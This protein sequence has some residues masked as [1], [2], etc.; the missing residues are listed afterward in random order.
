[1]VESQVTVLLIEDNPDD[2]TLVM[3]MISEVRGTPYK[4]EWADCLRI[5]K[6]RLGAVNPGLILLD[7]S[8]TDS[9][10]FETFS[11]VKQLAGEIPIIVLSGLDD[12]LLATRAVRHGAQDYL[13]KGEINS[14]LLARA[15]RYA[16]ERKEAALARER[17]IGELRSALANIRTLEGLLPICASC[18]RI[19]DDKGYWNQ[20]E[21]YIS[22]HSKAEFTHGICP[23]C[24]ARLYPDLAK[25]IVSGDPPE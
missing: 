24:F 15:M 4:V 25:K 19:R 3:E 14:Q 2:A 20:I 13:I 11:C 1:M 5:G 9:V 23:E 8:L 6:E 7:L 22:E 10:G 21:I 16:I 18:K 12:E 17:L